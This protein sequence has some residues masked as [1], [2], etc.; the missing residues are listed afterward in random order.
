MTPQSLTVVELFVMRLRLCRMFKNL[1]ALQF[2][3]GL[4]LSR[5]APL[6]HNFAFKFCLLSVRGRE[7]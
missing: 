4:H 2:A 7:V 6:P 3:R 5:L 1:L